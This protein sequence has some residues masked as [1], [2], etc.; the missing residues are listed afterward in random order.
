MTGLASSCRGTARALWQEP[1]FASSDQVLVLGDGT[2]IEYHEERD[3]FP[4]TEARSRLRCVEPTGE[5]RWSLI[6]PHPAAPDPDSNPLAGAFFY[7]EPRPDSEVAFYL[8][9]AAIA[10]DGTQ[11]YIAQWS[12]YASGAEVLALDIRDGRHVWGRVV[13][14]LGPIIHS[15][16]RTQV[17]MRLS[18]ATLIISGKEA[19]GNY[20]E[21]YT[22]SGRRLSTEILPR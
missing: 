3:D 14:G 8:G 13:H 15:R 4:R 19:A 16:Y 6:E 1:A 5:E 11:V 12:R 17:A 7:D 22:T 2:R 10:T 21:V 18:G 20:V 9:A